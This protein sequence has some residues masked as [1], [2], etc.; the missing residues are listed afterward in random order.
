MSFDDE[1]LAN[2]FSFRSK[3]TMCEDSTSFEFL[4]VHSPAYLPYIRLHTYFHRLKSF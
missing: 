2:S 3:G 1:T 4:Y